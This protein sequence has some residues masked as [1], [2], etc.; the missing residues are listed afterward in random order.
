VSGPAGEV[1]IRLLYSTSSEK[2]R[3]FGWNRE[4]PYAK[5]SYDFVRHTAKD[6][7]LLLY[8]SPGLLPSLVKVT[9]GTPYTNLGLVIKLEN[10][11]LIAKISTFRL[12]YPKAVYT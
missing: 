7:D 9:S 1:H 3:E 6:G 11:V 12:S 5:F 2:G 8:D 10:K 4:D